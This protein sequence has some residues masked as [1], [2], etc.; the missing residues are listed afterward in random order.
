M[1]YLPLTPLVSPMTIRTYL[2]PENAGNQL[3]QMLASNITPGD[4]PFNFSGICMAL[5]AQWLLELKT[6]N[7]QGPEELGRYLLKEWLGK[8]GYA[9]L[10]KSQAQYAR[11]LYDPGPDE[12][13]PS[14]VPGDLDANDIHTKMVRRHSG[15][16]LERSRARYVASHNQHWREIRSSVYGVEVNDDNINFEKAGIYSAHLSLC[17]VSTGLAAWLGGATWGHAI[18]L[19]S[20]TA[21]LF[22]FDPNYGVFVFKQESQGTIASFIQELW[23]EYNA[24]NGKIA[25]VI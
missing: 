18:G 12:R 24:T 16:M 11:Q 9:G 19:Y 13:D 21:H 22:F 20:D 15:G 14:D 23:A 7:E 17:G 1:T 10:A 4:H 3:W 6:S 5:V 2:K 8:V 25:D